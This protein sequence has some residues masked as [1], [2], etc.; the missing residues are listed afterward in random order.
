MKWTCPPIVGLFFFDL[1]G[2]ISSF[3]KSMCAWWLF[4]CFPPLYRRQD[5]S[6]FDKRILAT[7]YVLID[8]GD[9]Y[10]STKTAVD[11]EDLAKVFGG[12]GRHG[13]DLRLVRFAV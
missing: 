4:V 7:F 13:E 9:V 6:D 1:L 11:L 10:L 8:F 12:P 2:F 3:L 5:A